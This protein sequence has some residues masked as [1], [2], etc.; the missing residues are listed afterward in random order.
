M[1]QNQTQAQA[2]TMKK[3]LIQSGSHKILVC[4]HANIFELFETADHGYK[5]CGENH[6][7]ESSFHGRHD[8]KTH[9]AVKVEMLKPWKY[10][11]SCFDALRSQIDDR[12]FPAPKI[13]R[14]KPGYFE[15]R[16]DSVC[17]DRY[18]GGDPFWRRSKREQEIGPK[19]VTVSIDLATSARVPAEKILWRGIVGTVLCDILERSGYRV[20]LR[21]H[22]Y[23]EY[24][25][26]HSDNRLLSTCVIKGEKDFLDIVQTVNMTSG[27]FYRSIYFAHYEGTDGPCYGS[28][29]RPITVEEHEAYVKNQDVRNIASPYG[30]YVVSDCYSLNE[31]KETIKMIIEDVVKKESES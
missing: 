12:D 24:I 23:S 17:I 30:G 25:Y 6:A 9:E 27:W 18:R 28:L 21:V 14:R 22:S 26:V 1:N 13:K 2:A 31:A 29:G 5:V 3:S 16:G 11:M 4:E 7:K 19:I 8:I 10:G 20:Q 15:D